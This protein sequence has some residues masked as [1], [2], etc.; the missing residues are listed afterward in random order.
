MKYYKVYIISL[1]CITAVIVFYRVSHIKELQDN[2]KDY[3]Y[4]LV[5]P[6]NYEILDAQ[7]IIIRLSANIPREFKHYIVYVSKYNQTDNFILKI[8]KQCSD[9]EVFINYANNILDGINASIQGCYNSDDI[10]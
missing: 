6:L 10:I 4:L 3:S 9:A 1:V 7:D 2:K 5:A 8:N